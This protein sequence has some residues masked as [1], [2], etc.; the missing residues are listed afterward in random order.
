MYKSDQNRFFKGTA[1]EAFASFA[2]LVSRERLMESFANV[3]VMCALSLLDDRA[4][5][6]KATK[7][8]GTETVDGVETQHVN[9]GG[10]FPVDLYIQSGEK[11]WLK[12]FIVNNKEAGATTLR[13]R[14]SNWQENPTI[15]AGEFDFAPPAGAKE[16]T[17][18]SAALRVPQ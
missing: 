5:A 14:Y 15:D 10:S 6:F 7:F 4:N 2:G 12:Q 13:C 11:S 1:P 17:S 8:I 16:V 9:T 3:G 18:F